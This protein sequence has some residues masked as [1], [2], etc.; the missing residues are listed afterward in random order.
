MLTHADLENH[1]LARRPYNIYIYIYIY[2]DLENHRLA[3]DYEDSLILKRVLFECFDCYIALLYIA[4]YQLNCT[5][6]RSEVSVTPGVPSHFPLP[7][8]PSSS[9]PAAA[10][11]PKDLCVVT[12]G[13]LF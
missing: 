11:A 3:R 4:F 7:L 9:P 10:I 6:L 1:Q 2:I 13:F 5:R 8:P 12:W